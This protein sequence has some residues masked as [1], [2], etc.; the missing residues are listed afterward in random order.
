MTDSVRISS[1]H[2]SSWIE[3]GVPDVQGQVT[4]F[5]VTAQFEL[6]SGITRAS[7]DPG[8]SPAGLFQAAVENLNGWTGFKFW[9]SDGGELCL[10]L[11]MDSVGHC[12][13]EAQ[14]REW[15]LHTVH[16]TGYL[17]LE[18]G[19]LSGIAG[20]LT[21]LF[22]DTPAAIAP[23]QLMNFNSVENHRP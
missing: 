21:Q 11:Y 6:F 4:Y 3:F 17:L 23:G 18:L 9:N 5:E 2:G 22:A 13:L 19:S 7:A 14:L 10:R 1:A 8:D 12:G 16:L 15:P 20:R